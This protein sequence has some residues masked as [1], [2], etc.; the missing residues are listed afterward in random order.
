MSHVYFKTQALGGERGKSRRLLAYCRGIPK[1][2]QTTNNKSQTTLCCSKRSL[3]KK[4]GQLQKK[5]KVSGPF[6]KSLGFCQRNQKISM[7]IYKTVLGTDHFHC[8]LETEA[9]QA[10]ATTFIKKPSNP[11]L[12]LGCSQRSSMLI[13]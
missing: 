3:L 11:C 12:R 2:Q 8:F 13:L 9:D 10:D 1:W 4:D 5:T 7:Q 6:S